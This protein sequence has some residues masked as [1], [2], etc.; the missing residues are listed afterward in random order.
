MDWIQYTNHDGKSPMSEL[1]K[2][3]GREGPWN[4][5]FWGVGNET[6]G[7]G[8]MMTAEFYANRFRLYSS[9]MTNR[10]NSNNIYRVAAGAYGENYNWTEVLLKNIPKKLIEAIS[11]HYYTSA[12]G[13]IGAGKNP[14]GSAINFSPKD[15]FSI[16]LSGAK[17][18]KCG[19]FLNLKIAFFLKV[20]FFK[21]FIFIL[22][23]SN[24]NSL[25]EGSKE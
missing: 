17:I 25:S 1:R 19:S 21:L 22:S 2:K 7:C 16:L 14:S 10:Q 4:V 24:S 23:L 11:L 6:W 15:Y 18:L 8:G 3:N 20:I 13:V 5:K 12:S 9:F